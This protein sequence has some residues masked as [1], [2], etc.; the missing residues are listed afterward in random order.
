LLPA[1]P[2]KSYMD[3][4]SLHTCYMANPFTLDFIILIIF[5]EEYKL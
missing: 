2:P 1:V 5:G 3:S 4:S